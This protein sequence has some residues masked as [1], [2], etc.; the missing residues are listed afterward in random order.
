MVT[1]WMTLSF[2]AIELPGNPIGF[3][4]SHLRFEPLGWIKGH[5][6]NPLQV[7]DRSLV[8]FVLKGY[9]SSVEDRRA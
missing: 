6:L 2:S 1:Q 4:Q 8:V 5:P 3:D 7:L 9:Q